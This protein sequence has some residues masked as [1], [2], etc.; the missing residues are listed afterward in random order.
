[1]YLLSINANS[2]LPDS[3][4]IGNP[5]KKATKQEN[6]ITVTRFLRSLGNSSVMEAMRTSQPQLLDEIPKRINIKK[7]IKLKNGPGFMTLTASG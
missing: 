5:S 4:Q 2:K 1:M 3:K 6:I 7:N